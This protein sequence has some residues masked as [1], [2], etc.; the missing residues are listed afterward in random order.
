[1]VERFL[2]GPLIRP[3]TRGRLAQAIPKN[4]LLQPGVFRLGGDEDGMSSGDDSSGR[5][6]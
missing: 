6:P 1:M 2:H 5:T 4:L 3:S